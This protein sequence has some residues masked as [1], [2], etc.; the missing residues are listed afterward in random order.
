MGGSRAL[1]QGT[2]YPT[3]PTEYDIYGMAIR[4]KRVRLSPT[5]DVAAKS[6]DTTM[7]PDAED[8]WQRE[9]RNRRVVAPD[10]ESRYQKP[11]RAVTST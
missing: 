9:I 11:T 2:L 6:V 8:A 7:D 4:G 5:R 10:R 1:R 3:W